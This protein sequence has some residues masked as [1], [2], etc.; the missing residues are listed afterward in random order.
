MRRVASNDKI[1]GGIVSKNNQNETNTK[2]YKSKSNIRR[3]YFSVRKWY[4]KPKQF[5]LIVVF[6]RERILNNRKIPRKIKERVT[7]D[8][9]ETAKD[10][11]IDITLNCLKVEILS[12]VIETMLSLSISS[13]S[14][15]GPLEIM[16]HAYKIISHFHS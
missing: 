8:V 11:L 12:V 13:T 2:R 1:V 6:I 16:F 9:T 4:R 10:I 5:F 14:E 7:D 3:N 15:V